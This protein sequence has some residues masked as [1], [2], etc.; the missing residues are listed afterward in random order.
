MDILFNNNIL[1]IFPQAREE[2]V[3]E[4]VLHANVEEINDFSL[5]NTQT[6]IP[7]HINNHEPYT[8]ERQYHFLKINLAQALEVGT[9]YTLFLDYSNSMNEG[10]MKRGI[11]RGWYKDADGLEK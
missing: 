4:V 11:W 8:L 1:K 2:N 7:V 9:N 5:T 3:T 10:P 6:N